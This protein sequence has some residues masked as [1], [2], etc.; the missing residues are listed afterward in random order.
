MASAS[1]ILT[2]WVMMDDGSISPPLILLS[3]GH[4]S[5]PRFSSRQQN[6]RA[7]DRW[8]QSSNMFGYTSHLSINQATGVSDS[9]PRWA[10]SCTGL[11]SLRWT[12]NILGRSCHETV[13]S[14]RGLV[15]TTSDFLNS[16]V[17]GKDT[18]CDP[19]QKIVPTGHAVTNFGY[20]FKLITGGC[21]LCQSVFRW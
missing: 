14:S 19:A 3:N 4:R 8:F 9:H 2:V 10:S 12:Y 18:C 5:L 15:Y 17:T 21:L 20:D 6:H 7:D 11:A 16:A 13:F 1:S